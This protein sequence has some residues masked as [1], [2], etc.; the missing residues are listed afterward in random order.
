MGDE[1]L[2]KTILMLI[3][4]FGVERNDSAEVYSAKLMP[5]FDAI[6]KTYLFGN[7]LTAAGDYNNA[8]RMFS[9][10]ERGKRAEDEIDNLIYEKQLDQV[11]VLQQI[12][13]GIGPEN[14][15]HVFYALE[16]ANK[17]NQLR[18]F[19][20]VINPNKDKKVFVHL[21][22]TST[23][24]AA[25]DG[26]NKALSKIS[27]EMGDYCKVGM[28]VGRNKINSDDVLRA[29][30][31]ELGEHWSEANKKIEI[32]QKEV[33]NPENAGVF[34]ITG[35]CTLQEND[36]VLFL[37]YEDVEM[38]KFYKDFTNI[39]TKRYS[40][41]PYKDDVPHMFKKEDVKNASFASTVEK[42]GIKILH[43]TN[44]TRINDINFYLNGM[45]KRKSPNITYA[46]NDKSLFASKEAVI[47][48]VSGNDYDGFILDFS[49]VGYTK[50]DDIKKELSSLDA[51][52]KNI[53]DASREKDYT[54]IV[55]S[56]YGIHVPV[57][58]G[59]VQKV[60]NFS[61]KVPILFQSNIF[62]KQEYSLNT[63]NTYSLEQ[64]FL[65]NI[66]DEV[67]ANK[68]VHKLSSIEKM[69][70]KGK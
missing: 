57:M 54:F 40:L 19:M 51:I 66:N 60:I 56:L 70:T 4:G 22:L 58:D 67:K 1:N 49:I 33:I 29:F 35:G 38:E 41:Y 43:F 8:Y 15:L 27:F 9:I 61:G 55:S 52:I 62:N 39:P 36:S 63:G 46:V 11:P 5:N 69:L 18:E 32:L 6:I 26:I 24:T 37:N 53:S 3:N 23:S 20:H 59:V 25:Y 17:L 31:R 50:M 16:D 44:Q 28:V 10:P 13:D 42:Y 7:I 47:N 45:E 68:L 2:R 14:K 65:T 48:L 21:I 30:Y 12:R 64:T 34:I